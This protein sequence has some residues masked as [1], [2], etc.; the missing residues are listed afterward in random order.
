M[1]LAEPALER[2]HNATE[3]GIPL[4]EEINIMAWKVAGNIEWVPTVICK[5]EDH[6]PVV[7]VLRI[8]H[9]REIHR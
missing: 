3:P 1:F 6:L 2:I 7:L 9:R 4:E 8:G 5:I